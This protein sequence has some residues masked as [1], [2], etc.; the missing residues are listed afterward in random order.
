MGPG[1]QGPQTSP[2]HCL[3]HPDPAQRPSSDPLDWLWEAPSIALEVEAGMVSLVV[4]LCL[5][6]LGAV[7]GTSTVG[8]HLAPNLVPETSLYPWWQDADVGRD[9][10]PKGIWSWGLGLG[11][12]QTF[13][14]VFTEVPSLSLHSFAYL[15][16]TSL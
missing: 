2:A 13:L 16:P 1:L 10:P 6:V 7:L 5:P 9:W 15:R 8:H 14:C 4:G 3:A 12:A 11:Q